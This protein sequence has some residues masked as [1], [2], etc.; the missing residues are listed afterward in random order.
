MAG[1]LPNLHGLQLENIP[2]FF[3][4]QE[5]DSTDSTDSNN[6]DVFQIQIQNFFLIQKKNITTTRHPGCDFR[7]LLFHLS[8]L[9]GL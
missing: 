4:H 6:V 7:H 9:M 1:L 2:F 5:T 8:D 3:S